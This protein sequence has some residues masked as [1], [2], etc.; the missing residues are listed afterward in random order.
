M[1]ERCRVF[2]ALAERESEIA[3]RGPSHLELDVVPRRP[4][5]VAGVE[6]DRLRVALVLTVVVASV[7]QIDATLEG[8]VVVGSVGVSD[9]D[10]LLVVAAAAPHALVEDDL[11]S[12]LVDHL[13]QRRVALLGEVRLTRVR[14]PSS[15]RTCTPRR[16][17]SASTRPTSVPGPSRSSSW[18][19]CQS[20]K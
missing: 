4:A 15:P 8:D 14:S 7:T 12:G 3:D 6:T 2:P 13:G 1:V 10:Q 20:V 5:A 16:A 17:A 19:L 11:A 9:D 18:S